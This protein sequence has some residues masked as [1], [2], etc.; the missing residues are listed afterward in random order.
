MAKDRLICF[1]ICLT[2]NLYTGVASI[3]DH[4]VN[5]MIENGFIISIGTDDPAILDTT[6]DK[7]FSLFKEI[8]K[9]SDDDMDALRE[10]TLLWSAKEII[11]R[12]AIKNNS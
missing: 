3:H 2:S 9:A 7:E 4:P 8:T 6:L 11:K 12:K 1:D 10:S 5:K